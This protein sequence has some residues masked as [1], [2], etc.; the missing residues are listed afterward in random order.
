MLA[1]GVYH[2]FNFSKLCYFKNL[3][4]VMVG[5]GLADVSNVTLLILGFDV[6]SD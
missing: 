6:F 4:L 1:R 5:F 3:V 2:L